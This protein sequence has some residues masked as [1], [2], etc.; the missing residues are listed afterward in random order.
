VSVEPAKL[1]D[2][3]KDAVSRG[4]DVVA[5][6]G[7]DGTLHTAAGA[8]AGSK[9]RLLCVPTG[10]LNNFAR[11]IGI[12][13]IEEAGAALK[14]GTVES[15]ALGTLQDGVFLNT[16]TFGEYARVV[17]MRER[18]RRFLG[19]WP[20]AGVSFFV[21]AFSLR[22]ILVTLH[23]DGETIQRRTRLVWVGVGWGSFPRVY[24]APERRDHPDLEVAILRADTRRQGV[25]FVFRLAV[26]LIRDSGPVRDKDLEILQTRTLKL[27]SPHRVD[28]TSDGEPIRLVTPINL[29]VQDD[30]LVVFVGPAERES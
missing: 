17:R 2:A 21:S 6:A 19:K 1:A 20:A 18:L 13:T 29:G 7:G 16:V 30:A 14:T 12:T 28:A 11:R 23:V 9:T 22:R 4:A 27:E 26:A 24:E 5:V 25:A 8:L 10:T 3:I 15:I